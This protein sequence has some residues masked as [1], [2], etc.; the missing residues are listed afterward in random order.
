MSKTKR[1]YKYRISPTDEQRRILAQTFGCCRFVY[2]WGLGTRKTA[3][4]QHGQKLTYN[5]LSA[6]L[7]TLKQEHPWLSDVSSVPIQQSLRHLDRGT[8][9][10][11]PSCLVDVVDMTADVGYDW[12]DESFCLISI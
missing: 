12:S 9:R 1:A 11:E 2:N 6:M 7:P 8:V 5:D 3:Y 10:I 4:S